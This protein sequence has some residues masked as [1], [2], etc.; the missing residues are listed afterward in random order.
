MRHQHWEHAGTNTTVIIGGCDR[1]GTPVC[2]DLTRLIVEI[3]L[4]LPYVDPKIN[5]RISREHPHD[6]FRLLAELTAGGDNGLAI[7]N[8][9]VIIPANVQMGKALE[10]CRRYVG[11][12]CQENLLE[13]CE[14]NSRA[15]IYLNLLQVFLAGFFPE[16]LA[17]FAAR[18]GIRLRPYDGCAAFADMYAAFLENLRAVNDAHIDQRNRTEAEGWR[19]HPCP[20]H[21]ATIDDCLDRAAD[22]MAGGAR[23][24]FGSVSL[25]GVGTLVDSLYAVREAVFTRGDITLARLRALLATDFAGAEAERQYLIRRLPKYGREHP[26]MEAFTAQVFADLARVTSGK[27]N[28]RGGRYEASLFPFRA[29][30]PMGKITGA[31]PDGR[32]AGEPLS[33]GMSP[34][35]LALGGECSIGQVLD[36]L[37]PLDLTLYPVVAV[38]DVK[39]PALR[40]VSPDVLVP[41]LHRFLANGGSVLQINCVDPAVLQEAKIHPERHPDLVV[42]ISGYSAYFTTLPETLQDEVIART[43][44]TTA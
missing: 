41:V 8:D 23:Y 19:Y 32:R 42:R 35:P 3:R 37:K 18:A 4:E 43:L 36:A 5:A 11:G 27:A 33:P 29:F 28:T 34:S 26:E 39:L 40:R 15:T 7:F 22:M 30:V 44:V 21:S 20:L 2:N 24:S 9:E 31:T 6:Y 38:L 1:D 13:N 10:D 12:G 16:R 17:R 25:T 14:V